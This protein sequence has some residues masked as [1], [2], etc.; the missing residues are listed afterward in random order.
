MSNNQ[1][2]YLCC[3]LPS[4]NDYTSHLQDAT[5]VKLASCHQTILLAC[6]LK[7]NRIVFQPQHLVGT[8]AAAPPP[9]RPSEPALCGSCPLVT[10]Y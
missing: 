6:Q 10:P 7:I 2:Q 4:A 5:T 3:M 9:F 1:D 8:A